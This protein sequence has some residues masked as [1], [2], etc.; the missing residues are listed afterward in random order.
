MSEHRH[1]ATNLRG[2]NGLVLCVL[3]MVIASCS[4][5]EVQ[6]GSETARQLVIDILKDEIKK[7]PQI[8]YGFN[9][10]A[11]QYTVDAIRTKGDLKNGK[12]CAARFT[13]QFELSDSLK[14]VQKNDPSAFQSLMSNNF[15]EFNN[16][17]LE[18][19]IT[20]TVEATEDKQIYVEVQL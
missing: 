7:A 16:R 14:Q 20:Y 17:K 10:D 11:S 18:R 8:A 15:R 5:K 3:G 1:L 13:A 12:S 4:D 6:C 19:D 9:V 2:K